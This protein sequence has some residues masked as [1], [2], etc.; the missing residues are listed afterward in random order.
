[1]ILFNACRQLWMPFAELLDSAPPPQLEE[2]I[3]TVASNMPGVVGLEKC[4]ARKMGF[5]YYVDLHVVVDGS[6]T[7]RQGHKIA[8]D[9]E[10]SVLQQVPTVAEVLVHIEPEE[11]LLTPALKG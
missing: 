9:V 5:R 2:E 11:E 7:V 8:H 6:L 10:D 3:R 1:V 4:H